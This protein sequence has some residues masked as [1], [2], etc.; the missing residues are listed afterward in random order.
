MKITKQKSKKISKIQKKPI[1][2]KEKKK[3]STKKIKKVVSKEI[4]KV[5]T[6]IGRKKKLN[7]TRIDMSTML[8][9]EGFRPVYTF[10]Y[11]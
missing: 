7:Y 5:I 3:L 10:R 4:E 1:I 2:K 6:K 8:P 11:I 9:L